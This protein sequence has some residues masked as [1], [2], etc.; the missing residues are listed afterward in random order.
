MICGAL[1]LVE[2][3][4]LSG[5][6]ICLPPYSLPT[7]SLLPPYP[8]DGPDPQDGPEDD[9][10]DDSEEEEAPSH[11]LVGPQIPYRTQ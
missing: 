6:G 11:L 5:L 2:R 10:D 8:Q 1:G 7:P 3:W 4:E 9:V